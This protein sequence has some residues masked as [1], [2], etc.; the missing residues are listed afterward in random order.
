MLTR[1]LGRSRF[2]IA[3]VATSVVAVVVAGSALALRT[4]RLASVF[5]WAAGSSGAERLVTEPSSLGKVR[6]GRAFDLEAWQIETESGTTCIAL[7]MTDSRTGGVPPNYSDAFANAGLDCGV[8]GAPH[9]PNGINVTL[10]WIPADG[11]A[12]LPADGRWSV[13]VLGRVPAGSAVTHAT[14][15]TAGS[16]VR[17]PLR[18]RFFL[19][20]LP[21][22]TPTTDA[23]PDSAVVV[24]RGANGSDIARTDLSKL[25][26]TGLR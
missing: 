3:V 4:D 26:G 8:S 25:A 7:R 2:R 10:S 21:G 13:V 19:A 20:L 18:D 23:L 6:V 5:P 14:L 12:G 16:S 9:F 1:A 17:L 24:A 15:E 11:S 22:T